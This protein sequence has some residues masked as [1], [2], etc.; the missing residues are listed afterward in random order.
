M[1]IFDT[2]AG[3]I[4]AAA[5][6]ADPRGAVRAVLCDALQENAAE[7][8]EET[9]PG[10]PDEI[11]LY[12]DSRLSI[13]RS[14]FQPDVIMPAHEHQLPVLIACYSGAE[15][16]ILYTREGGRLQETGTLTAAE[17]EVIELPEDAIHK[18][19]AEGGQPSEAVHV[20]FGPLT[21]LDRALFDPDTGAALPFTME[22]FEAL[23]MPAG[24]SG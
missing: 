24:T 21:T 10:G 7:L 1:S 17:G 11:N 6:D 22:N 4:R 8:R 3:R 2:L 20:Y 23:K 9:A 13:W 18:V 19:T 12:E 15:K 16:S 14:R 5:E